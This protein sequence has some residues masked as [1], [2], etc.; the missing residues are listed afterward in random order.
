MTTTSTAVANAGV[1]G[2]DNIAPI[3]NPN[4][5]WQIWNIDEIYLGKTG[6]GKYIP[7]INDEIH[8]VLDSIINRYVVS[9]INQVTLVPTLKE[10]SLKTQDSVLGQ[11][12]IL[13]GTGQWTQSDTYR[14]YADT[15]VYPYRLT[16]DARL[17]V[18]GTMC[19]YA[20]IFYGT[21]ITKDGVVISEIY[22]QNGILSSENVPLEVVAY[23]DLT[24]SAIKTV[25]GC[26]TTRTFSD[27]ELLAIVFYDNAGFVV[28]KRQLMV[29]NTGFVRSV[30]TSQ[31]YVIG[32]SLETPFLSSSAI[33]TIN[34][35]LNVPVSGMNLMGV[36]HYSDGAKV[37]LAVDGNRFS[38]AGLEAYMPTVVGQK[39]QVVLKYSF[40]SN[41][42]A[43]GVTLGDIKHISEI[44][45]LVTVNVDG[46]YA[47][48]LY[49]YPVWQDETNGYLLKWFM[50]DLDRS[51]SLNVTPWVV[52]NA[53]KSLFNPTGYGIKQSLTASI[54]LSK[55]DGRYKKFTHIQLVEITLKLSGDNRPYGDSLTNWLS[56]VT[57]GKAVVFGT[58]TYATY[59][60][61]SANRWRVQLDA[62]LSARADWLDHVYKRTYPLYDN[63]IESQAPVPTHFKLIAG[64]NEAIYPISDWNAEIILNQ[65]LTNGSTVYLKFIRRTTDIDLQLSVAGLQLFQIDESGNFV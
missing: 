31:R 51:V 37:R 65:A 29:E 25:S 8:E 16:V 3:Y 19:S 45:D 62:N 28:S 43:Y 22:N 61:E 59:Y 63:R 11:D 53:N 13:L 40:Q 24:N 26:H 64:N 58:A 2:T 1:V 47:V 52:I 33:K 15:S 20:K 54:D 49:A 30:N 50:Y 12:D 57:S 60:R 41:E 23:N 18:A 36:V 9:S 35:P 46:S 7:K 4:D 14:I 10:I 17:K 6:S 32:I 21:N 48:Q 55:V 38:I 5:R 39:T 42:Y 34:Y 27:G 44:Y 56:C